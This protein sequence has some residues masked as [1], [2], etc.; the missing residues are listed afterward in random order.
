MTFERIQYLIYQTVKQRYVA[1]FIV[2]PFINLEIASLTLSQAYIE[3]FKTCDIAWKT[4]TIF[5]YFT[6]LASS[7]DCFFL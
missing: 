6:S 4:D 2:F 3:V 7:F 5:K 1:Y